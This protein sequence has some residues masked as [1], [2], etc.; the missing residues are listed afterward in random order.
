MLSP[1]ARPRGL[2]GF[3]GQVCIARRGLDLGVTEQLPDHGQAL[4]ERQGAGRKAVPQV[5]DPH[6]VEF[7]AGRGYGARDAE[8]RS[9]GRPSFLPT[10]TQG[11]SSGQG[12]AERTLTA[13]PESGT[14]RAPVLP[15]RSL[16]SAASRF[17]SSQ[18]SVLDLAQSGSRSA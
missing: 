3:I 5:V 14:I 9:D 17:T 8:D 4:P 1:D 16:I 10:I 13:A 2:H 15:S 7:R 6:V 18:R 12:R 11:L